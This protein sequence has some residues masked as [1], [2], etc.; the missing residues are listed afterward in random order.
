MTEDSE[1]HLS[2]PSLPNV[3]SQELMVSS[4]D[5]DN[6]NDESTLSESNKS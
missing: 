6:D 4:D 2:Y 5:D 3:W 1:D